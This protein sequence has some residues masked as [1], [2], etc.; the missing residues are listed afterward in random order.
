MHLQRYV[1]GSGNISC[2]SASR[3]S[4]IFRISFLV[5]FLRLGFDLNQRLGWRV[6][7]KQL[8]VCVFHAR[9]V[10]HSITDTCRSMHFDAKNQRLSRTDNQFLLIEFFVVALFVPICSHLLL[11]FTFRCLMAE[12]KPKPF[13][14]EMNDGDVSGAQA[15]MLN[16][17]LLVGPAK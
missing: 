11:C 1:R 4:A 7:R 3:T 10:L 17:M 5:S 2:A 9:N 6:T 12:A 15:K 8:C 13:E 14:K 16:D